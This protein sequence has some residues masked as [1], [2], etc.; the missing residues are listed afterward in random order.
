M[1]DEQR[2]FLEDARDIVDKLSVD[3]AELR[4]EGLAGRRRR[5]LAAQ[6]FRRVHTL[7]GSAASLGHQSIAD[8]SHRF[9]SILDASRLGQLELDR[10]ALDT[11]AAAVAEIERLL[12]SNNDS[13][14]DSQAIIQRLAKHADSAKTRDGI[15]S[16]LRAV[17]P[18]ELAASLSEYDLHHAVS[19]INEGAR[20]FVVSA[21]FSLESFDSAFR[22]LSKLLGEE[23]E[24]IATIPGAPAADNELSFRIVYATEFFSNE[25]QRRA[26]ALAQIRHE[27]IPVKPEE[28][29][30][31]SSD[32]SARSPQGEVATAARAGIRVD[33]ASLGELIGSAAELFRQTNNILA[34]IS[35][36]SIITQSMINDVR[37]RFIAF[38]DR[39]IKLRLVA[40]RE[41]LERTVARTGRA[42]ARQLGKDIRF[43]IKAGDVGIERSLAEIIADPLLHLVRNAITHGIESPEERRA[44]GKDPSGRVTLT[45]YSESGK[46][47]VTVS[48]DGRGIDLDRVVVAAAEHG[49]V[50]DQ[51]TEEQC[52]RL[53]FRPGFSTS[54]DVSDLSG[55]GIGLDVVDR[56]MGV[57]GGEVR[58][59]T[60]RGAGATFAMIVPAALSLVNCLIVRNGEHFYAIDAAHVQVNGVDTLERQRLPLVHLATLVGESIDSP[61]P[62]QAFVWRRPTEAGSAVGGLPGYRIAVDEIVTTQET[63]VRGLGRHAYRWTGVSGAAE[64]FDGTVAL[65]LDLSE[66]IKLT[67]ENAG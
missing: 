39:L 31:T 62:S 61:E 9:E 23:G 40:A 46:I 3:I 56:A 21:A 2:L 53:I 58:V 29:V 38:E 18:P 63:L 36:S 25:L 54:R 15:V 13:G 67:L 52:L 26:S 4:V 65:V 12:E 43:E 49:I 41:I 20:L 37:M 57:A 5:H 35:P 8:I 14:G 55:R 50:G 28:R 11:F 6:V 1:N 24:V 66:L 45:A 34:C 47:Y 22:E 59:A 16:N 17:L 7:K 30:A 19:A 48:D 42:A 44:A 10:P 32:E 33:E 27:E 60:K 64:M 51:L